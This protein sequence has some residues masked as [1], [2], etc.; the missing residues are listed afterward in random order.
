MCGVA[1]RR[2]AHRERL[3]MIVSQLRVFR[4]PLLLLLLCTA[5]AAAQAQ[6]APDFS[7]TWQQDNDRCQPKRSGDV[8]LLVDHRDPQLTVETTI[9]RNGQHSRHAI[10]IYATNGTV[11]VSTGADGD[12]FHTSVVRDGA[13]LIFTVEEH[14]DGRILRSRESWSLIEND[15]TLQ[16]TREPEHGEKQI[17]IYR[18]ESVAAR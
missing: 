4:R 15:A 7:G 3:Q 14:E 1:K 9:A 10:Q 2:L 8:T 18:R 6:T 13:R 5:M 16:R 12:E 17:L 11:S